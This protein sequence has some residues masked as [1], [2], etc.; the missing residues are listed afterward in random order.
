MAVPASGQLSL[1]KVYRELIYDNYNA[2][3]SIS[4]V[5]ASL[6]NMSTGATETLNTSGSTLVP[7]GSAP[8]KMSE[9]R[10]Y[11]HDASTATAPTVTTGTV[12]WNSSE[13]VIEANGN[14][15]SDGGATITQ[16]GFAYS[17][18]TT[19]PTSPIQTATGTTGLMSADINVIQSSSSYNMYVR[20]FAT[21]SVGTSYGVTRTVT[22]PRSRGGFP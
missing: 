21:N 17:T 10:G 6:K 1:G 22:V 12:S 2:S 20:A 4:G 19:T 7:D 14:V 13:V 16:R 3:T 18:T 15:S 8:H 11:D 5:S 9:W